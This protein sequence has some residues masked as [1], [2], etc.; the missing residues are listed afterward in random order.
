MTRINTNVSALVASNTLQKNMVELEESLTRLSTGLRINSGK[1]DPAG[2]IAS[3]LLRSDITAIEKGISNSE[4]ANQ[5]IATAD[6]AL[7]Q[8]SKLLN[9]I[10]GLV[11]EAA[12]TGGMSAEQIAANQLQVDSSLEAIDRIAK[13]TQFQG[14]RLLDGSLD[15]VTQGVD[16][17]KVED[18]QIDQ[19]NFGTTSQVDVNIEIV[20]TAEKGNLTFNKGAVGE[21]VVIEVGGNKGFEAFNFDSGS[22]IEEMAAAINL[23]S[24]STGVTANVSN[25]ST[26]AGLTA[27]SANANAAM[28]L[29]VD[30]AGAAG[31][32][33]DIKVVAS[34]TGSTNLDYTAATDDDEHSSLV[35]EAAAQAWTGAS[36]TQL[37]DASLGNS[38]TAAVTTVV[39]DD[40]GAGTNASTVTVTA[41]G[42]GDEGQNYNVRTVNLVDDAGI[43]GGGEIAAWDEK[44][45]T[46]TVYIDD[47]VTTSANV[48]T[49]INGL[50]NFTAA[51]SGGGATIT[52][53]N[54]AQTL[55]NVTVARGAV[56]DN[57]LDITAKVAGE[58][59]QNT[60]VHVVSGNQ[61]GTYAGID[62]DFTLAK[63]TFSGALAEKDSMFSVTVRDDS[64]YAGA[65]ATAA[66]IQ[67]VDDNSATLTVTWDSANDLVQVN[68]DWSAANATTGPTAQD[69]VDAINGNAD[70]NITDNFYAAV[71]FGDGT[72]NVGDITAAAA[73]I[74]GGAA[75]AQASAVF[76]AAANNLTVAATAGGI[77][78]GVGASALTVNFVDDSTLTA[79]NY[80]ASLDLDTNTLTVTADLS[81]TGIL[82]ADIGEFSITEGATTLNTGTTKDVLAPYVDVTS[83][84]TGFNSSTYTASTLSGYSLNELATTP[85]SYAFIDATSAAGTGGGIDVAGV[86]TAPGPTIEYREEATASIASV[87]G[88]DGAGADTIA[89]VVTAATVGSEYNDTK[90]Q[91]WANGGG[92][93]NEAVYDADNDVLKVFGDYAGGDTW[94]DVIDRIDADGTFTA[95]ID[96]TSGLAGTGATAVNVANNVSVAGTEVDLGNT[97]KSGGDAGTLFMYVEEGQT[98]AQDI[99]DALDKSWNA[100]A[101]NLFDIQLSTDE[102]GTG[103]MF[104]IDHQDALTGGVNGGEITATAEDIIN[105]INADSELAGILSAA[106]ASGSLGI[107]TVTAFEESAYYGSA[108]DGT[109]LQFLAPEDARD[110]RF[111]ASDEA[112]ALSV[113]WT[114]VPDETAQAKATL[115]AENADASLIFTAINQGEAFDDVVVRFKA[116]D[117]GVMDSSVTYSA[118]E[119][120]AEAYMTF[121]D[122]DSTTMTQNSNFIVTASEHGDKFNDADINMRLQKNNGTE[123]TL[124]Q[125]ADGN[126]LTY[127]DGSEVKAIATYDETTGELNVVLKANTS[128]GMA[129]ATRAA[130]ADDITANDIMRAINEE[131]TFSAE[132]DFA[133]DS[134]TNDGSGTGFG[135]LVYNQTKDDTSLDGVLN[136]GNTGTTGGHE[137]GVLEFTLADTKSTAQDVIDTIT[138]D[139]IVGKKFTAIGFDPT[140][141]T[142]EIDFHN[143]TNKAITSGG[144]AEAGVLTVNLETD[145]NGIVQ[146]T[147]ADLV[148]FFAT[149]TPEQNH[150]VSVS[151]WN[152]PSDDPTAVSDGSG[153][154]AATTT[155]ISFTTVGKTQTEGFASGEVT[156][157]NGADAGFTLTALK[158]GSDYD[159]VELNYV[160]DVATAADAYVEYDADTKELTVHAHTST[161]ANDVETLVENTAATQDLFSVTQR[162][163]GT[164][165][166]TLFDTTTLS[167]GLAETGSSEG[168]QLINGRDAED[169][170]LTFESDEY[171]SD[172]FVTVKSIEGDF[173]VVDS[174][175][176]TA[177][178]DLGEDVNARLNGIGMVGAGLNASINTNVLDLNFNVSL[179][180]NAGDKLSFSITGG[181]AT[182]QLGPEVVSNQQSRLGI[183]SVST[184][185]LGGATGR[186]F[187]LRS[188][189][190][191]DLTK[192]VGGAASIVQEVITQVTG[193]RGRLGA[194]QRTTVDTNIAALTDTLESLTAAESSIRDTDFATETTALT[195][196]QILVQSGVSVLGIAKQNPNMMLGLLR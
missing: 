82:L 25:D 4:R 151:L 29:T 155:D 180:A 141:T 102:D 73:D 126:A 17:T 158:K 101:S 66:Q 187:Q 123:D 169:V 114:S 59:F 160:L 149:L 178:R 10:R 50:G 71:E 109:G 93:S 119:S 15:F 179:D 40:D 8:V 33:F 98:T 46:I 144:L 164:G 173:Q 190:D 103:L 131:G 41:T 147:A 16:T 52:L 182:F 195:R 183:K 96:T 88:K 2:L 191:H 176:N 99:V 194:F 186:L 31:N 18:L 91:L 110:I 65:P 139:S 78:D 49:A 11:V 107:G 24:D 1:D 171:G 84:G 51:D 90:V 69:I 35:I 121:T 135:S 30:T 116:A 70:T 108:I 20:E 163:N 38:G 3:E 174:D 60:D 76:G 19:A 127:D 79:G 62:N 80:S 181:G 153:T 165:T 146:T 105:A 36:A 81:D 170:S 193:L 134:R 83:A 77:Y 39:Y 28:Q 156:A 13:V 124:F 6:S 133:N 117:S 104:Q 87:V 111:A 154:L 72:E 94:Q 47:T 112:Q 161:T 196:S 7:G 22:T 48:A 140:Q 63:S 27:S 92:F 67:F 86:G 64:A 136:V 188:G 43:T 184:V 45:G 95:S 68:Y 128:A 125:D 56:D 115:T 145:E 34:N 166:V 42:F 9:D 23:V 157:V 177:E 55:D 192:D 58:Q 100:T 85:G 106:N 75:T 21:D 162:G 129:E 89:L 167:G 189:Q 118:E 120:A 130:T 97:G 12:N 138:N 150:G 54:S 113:D 172:Q 53:A 143:D 14:K 5:V 175:G 152:A 122:I 32:N 137:G 57:A 142:G 74:G 132:L 26:Q 168:V 44:T 61:D 148:D 159:G 37:D 185:T